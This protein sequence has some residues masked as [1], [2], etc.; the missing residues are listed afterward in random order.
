M[1]RQLLRMHSSHFCLL[2]LYL[3]Y[4]FLIITK[5]RRLYPLLIDCQNHCPAPGVWGEGEQGIQWAA[6]AVPAGS[7]SLGQILGSSHGRLG[8][9]CSRGCAEQWDPGRTRPL[10]GVELGLGLWPACHRIFPGRA[11]AA[12][13]PPY[14]SSPDESQATNLGNDP[15]FP[16]GYGFLVLW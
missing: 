15:L 11:G 12:L 9:C 7:H 14:C 4:F 16:P 6:V 1:E 2:N 3:R 10:R 5:V 8:S 13:C